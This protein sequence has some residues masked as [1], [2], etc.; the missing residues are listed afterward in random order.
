MAEEGINEKFPR[1]PSLRKHLVVRVT[2]GKV[3]AQKWPAPR[4]K[5]RHPT[6]IFWSQWLAEADRAWKLQPAAF[7]IAATKAAEGG[8]LLPRD[9]F[10]AASRGR[11][12]CLTT[13]DGTE[14]YPLAAAED[15]TKSLDVLAQTPGTMLIRGSTLWQAVPPG[16]LGQVLTWVGA[17]AF[18]AWMGAVGGVAL[19]GARIY[20]QATGQFLTSGL[21]SIIQMDTVDFASAGLPDLGNDAIL[22]DEDGLWVVWGA[23]AIQNYPDQSQTFARI[24]IG[25]VDLVDLEDAP[26]RTGTYSMEAVALVNVTAAPKTANLVVNQNS[27]A[28]RLVQTGKTRTFLS[29]AYLGPLT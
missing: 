17:P 7:Q 19:K 3:V 9:L 29:A 24:R 21:A 15:V 25:G 26:A 22:L 14:I 1:Q 8:P 28:L 5:N 27:G 2:Q 12:W 4:G 20:A 6:N 23:F 13:E 18:A 10:I 11:L 16:E